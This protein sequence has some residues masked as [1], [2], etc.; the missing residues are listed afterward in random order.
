MNNN[1]KRGE[2]AVEELGG[3]VQEGIGKL[4]GN[5]RMQAEGRAHKL[6]GQ[7]KQEAA[8]AAA[9]VKGKAEEMMGAMKNRVGAVVGNERMQVE[10][11]AEE[12]TG[13]ARQKAN[14]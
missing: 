10:G 7:A 9:R 14:G 8:K 12:L 11:K 5:E 3:M 6:A 4:V 13:Q 2:G 1:I